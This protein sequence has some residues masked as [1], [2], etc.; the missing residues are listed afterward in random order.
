MTQNWKY[1][2]QDRD[3][4]FR[5]ADDGQMLSALVASEDIQDFILGGGSIEEPDIAPAAV[6]DLST[7]LA[8]LLIAKG[9]I[10]A[11]DLHPDT[12]ADVNAQLV[13]AGQDAISTEV[14]NA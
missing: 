8:A 12:L 10:A 6:P 9:T 1:K 3:V 2:T 11:D 13:D 7:Q 5:T 4:V 14:K